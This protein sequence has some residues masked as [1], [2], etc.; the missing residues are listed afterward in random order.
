[1]SGSTVVA[2]GAF[3]S[4]LWLSGN[5]EEYKVVIFR[6]I[7]GMVLYMHFGMKPI[8]VIVI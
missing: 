6:Y 3:S 8:I 4:G 5:G 2:I 1:M 7:I